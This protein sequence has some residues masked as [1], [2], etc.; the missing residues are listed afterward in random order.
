VGCYNTVGLC[1]GFSKWESPNIESIIAAGTTP[2]S[3]YDTQMVER[4]EQIEQIVEFPMIRE[5]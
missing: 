5:E 2:T 4:D 1:R 3:R